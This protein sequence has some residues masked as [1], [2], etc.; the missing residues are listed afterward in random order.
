MIIIHLILPG[1][2]L[3]VLCLVLNL[4]LWDLFFFFVRS[5]EPMLYVVF[6]EH[7]K[8]LGVGFEF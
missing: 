8:L 6:L 7:F 1:L 5:A 3:I 4:V 2:F